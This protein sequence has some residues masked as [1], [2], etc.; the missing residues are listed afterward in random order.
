M[1]EGVSSVSHFHNKIVPVK[2]PTARS[3]L[4]GENASPL[5]FESDAKVNDFISAMDPFC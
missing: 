2:V 1:I 5:T 3:L 4:S